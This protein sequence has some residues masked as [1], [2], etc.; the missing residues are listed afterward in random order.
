MYLYFAG[1]YLYLDTRQTELCNGVL[2]IVF[3]RLPPDTY[4]VAKCLS[5]DYN[6]NG[7]HTGSLSVMDGHNFVMWSTTRLTIREGRS[8]WVNHK[9]TLSPS[10]RLFAFKMTRGGDSHD[11]LDGKIAIDNIM[12]V[13]LSCDGNVCLHSEY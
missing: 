8:V 2:Y 3:P 5:F 1:Y 6:I 10:Q 13:P 12:V 4:G 9:I 7:P 11:D